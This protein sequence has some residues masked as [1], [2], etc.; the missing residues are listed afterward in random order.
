[1]NRTMQQTMKRSLLPGLV[2]GLALAAPANLAV[3]WRPVDHSASGG[4]VP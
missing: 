1:M 3:T 2:Y 4:S